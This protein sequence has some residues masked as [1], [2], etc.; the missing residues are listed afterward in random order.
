VSSLV[1]TTVQCNVSAVGK[2]LNIAH[3]QHIG[4]GRKVVAFPKKQTI[5][6]EGDTAAWYGQCR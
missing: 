4:E 3:F 2:M 6:T 5:F 1:F